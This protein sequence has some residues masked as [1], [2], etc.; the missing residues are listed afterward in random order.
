MAR[1]TEEEQISLSARIRGHLAGS[2]YECSSLTLLGGG[3]A[4]FVYRGVLVTPLPSGAETVIVKHTTGFLAVSRDF[5]I[6]VSRCNVEAS[7]LNALHGLPFQTPRLLFFDRGNKIQV[8]EDFP[9]AQGL[10][11]ILASPAMSRELATSVG[12]DLGA[13]LRSFHDWVSQPAQ[14]GL[15]AEIQCNEPMRDLNFSTTYKT[16]IGVL[17]K[18]PGVVD[19]YYR[20]VLEEVKAMATAEFARQPSDGDDD[21][22]GLIHGDYWGGNVLLTA[23]PS[24]DCSNHLLVIDWE[25][26]QYGHRAY[27]LG[28]MFGDL[29]EKRFLDGAEGIV[30]VIEGFV[31]G[32]GQMS[33]EL[34][35]RT[36]IHTGTQFIHW[37]VRR[38]PNAELLAAP[39]KIAEGMKLGRDLIVKGWM[40]DKEWFKRTPLA[41]LYRD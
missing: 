13:C 40:R 21:S 24:S 3:S 34:A 33:E 35:F 29:F 25:L 10:E 27:D 4:N 8:H 9:T 20:D 7:M 22:W 17:E 23:A 41:P 26:S 19:G 36:A 28:K 11:P 32:Y 16:F 38:P 18:F 15:A 6:D 14:R 39:E 2:Q 31:D 1:L 5:K 12:R 30:W 37:Y